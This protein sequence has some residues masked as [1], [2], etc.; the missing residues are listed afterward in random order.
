MRQFAGLP[1]H[2]AVNPHHP[3]GPAM[4]LYRADR[5]EQI[6]AGADFASA[7]EIADKRQAAARKGLQTRAR[8]AAAVAAENI[9]S[10][11]LPPAPRLELITAAVAWFNSG[12]TWRTGAAKWVS[13]ADPAAVLFPIV[14]S[15]IRDRLREYRQRARPVGLPVE[16]GNLAV[17]QKIEEAIALAYPWLTLPRMS[18]TPR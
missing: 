3:G 10:P 11:V 4:R 8:N 15:F 2:L 14:R 12:E 6:E 1:D 7:R 18:A 5:I 13:T 17:D 9:P 16:Q